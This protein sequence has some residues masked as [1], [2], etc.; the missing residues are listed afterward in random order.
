MTNQLIKIETSHYYGGFKPYKT[1]LINPKYIIKVIENETGENVK[2]IEISLNDGCS[3]K[4][5]MSIDE[6][7][8]LIEN[9]EN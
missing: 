7:N 2:Y 8:K 1:I 3:Y 4:V 9:I 6:L 5:L